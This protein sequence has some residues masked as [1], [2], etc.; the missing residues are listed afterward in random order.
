MLWAQSIGLRPV[1]VNEGGRAKGQ[2][3]SPLPCAL[4]IFFYLCYT[5]IIKTTVIS[6]NK[7]Q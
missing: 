3:T 5:K 1:F 7:P 2:T 4:D 6:P